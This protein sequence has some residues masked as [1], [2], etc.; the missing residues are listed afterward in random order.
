MTTFHDFGLAIETGWGTK[1]AKPILK[2]RKV[3]DRC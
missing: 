2:I 3:I 1:V